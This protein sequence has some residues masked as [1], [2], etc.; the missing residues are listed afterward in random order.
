MRQA[1]NYNMSL[2][3][4]HP[5]LIYDHGSF[6]LDGR[7]GICKSSTARI[8]NYFFEFMYIYQLILEKEENFHLASN[9]PTNHYSSLHSLIL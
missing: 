7:V 4:E 5:F 9:I 3:K 8:Q 1:I 6:N 2:C